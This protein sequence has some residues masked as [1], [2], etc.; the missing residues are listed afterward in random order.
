MS[1]SPDLDLIDRNLRLTEYPR[2]LVEAHSERGARR[3]QEDRLCVCPNMGSDDRG[4]FAVFDGTVGDFAS[5]YIH[6]RLIRH[7]VTSR[8]YQQ[9]LASN[10]HSDHAKLCADALRDAFISGDAELVQACADAAAHY[11]STTGV[12]AFVS[13]GLLTVGHIGDSRI[14]LGTEV[15]GRL[16]SEFLTIDHK[17][18]TPAEHQRIEAC[19]GS[20]A[21]LHGGKPFIRGGDFTARQQQGDRPMQLNYSRAFGGK[22][23]KMFGLSCEPD[24]RQVTLNGQQR[25][26]VLASDG[27]WDVIP[28]DVA[29]QVALEARASGQSASQKLVHLGLQELEARGSVDNVTA[30][31]IFFK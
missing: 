26:L 27:L 23:L 24:I 4:Y 25:V 13:K 1:Y 7:L 14:A 9:A 28:A 16:H 22:D 21:W 20:L 2:W 6:N 3:H 19:G 12:A 17:P 18:D 15:N 10:N 30:V 29:C 5:E 11:S 31:V 8:A